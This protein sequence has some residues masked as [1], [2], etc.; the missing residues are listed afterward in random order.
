MFERTIDLLY[1]DEHYAWIKNF[2]RFMADLSSHNTL[3]WCRRC[4]GHFDTED[5]LKTDKLYCRGVDTSGQVL[6]LPDKNRK[7]KFENEPYATPSFPKF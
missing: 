7:V 5:V 3:H 2:R 1:W 6:L 4:M